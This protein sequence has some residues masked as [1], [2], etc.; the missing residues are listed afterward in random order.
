MMQTVAPI[1]FSVDDGDHTY[2][3]HY[4]YKFYEQPDIDF[5]T[6]TVM[7]LL[8]NLRY[9]ILLV[10]VCVCVFSVLQ[11]LVSAFRRLCMTMYDFV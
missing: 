10:C 8:A 5:L 2:P 4:L 9:S 6:K 3:F 7:Q 1:H 11:S